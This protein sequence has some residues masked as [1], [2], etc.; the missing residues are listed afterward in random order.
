[1][2]NG[3]S[4]CP[5]LAQQENLGDDLALCIAMIKSVISAALLLSGLFKMNLSEFL[6]STT[7]DLLRT[8]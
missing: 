6:V 2:E 4:G 5:V 7:S 1:M 3:G 8:V